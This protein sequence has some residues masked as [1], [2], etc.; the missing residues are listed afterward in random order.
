LICDQGAP[1][2]RWRALVYSMTW[3]V[4]T[5][6]CL[7]LAC[8]AAAGRAEAHAS[9]IEAAPPDG[10]VVATAPASVRLRFNEPV[11]LL[12]LR[13]IDAKGVTHTDLRYAGRDETITIMLPGDLPNG[14]QVLSYRVTSSDG[15][16]IGGSLIFSIGAPTASL[17][18]QGAGANSLLAPAIWLARLALYVGLFAGAGGAFFTTW[19]G[20]KATTPGSLSLIRVATGIGIGAAVV[21]VG[22]QGL[23]ALGLPLSALLSLHPWHEGL[24]TSFGLTAGTA[25]LALLCAWMAMRGSV[26]PVALI[27]L[28]GAGLALALS[29]HASAASPQWLTRFS[30]FLHGLAAAFWIGALVPL[31]LIVRDRRGASLPIVERF[32]AIAVPMVGVMVLAGLILSVVQVETPA[33]LLTTAYG[34]VFLV[35]MAVVVCLLAVAVLN[36]QRLSPMLG[37]GSTAS[38]HLARSIMGEIGLAVMILGLVATWRFTPPPRALIAPAAEPVNVHIHTA[39]A[40][41]DMSLRPGRVGPV[42]ITM[43]LATGDLEPLDPKEVTVTLANPSAGIEPM[44][45]RAVKAADGTW[46]VEGLVVP[47]PGRW[48][49][50]VDV[51]ITD[52]EKATLESTVEIR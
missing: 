20:R 40:M 50:R 42:T 24:R 9:L 52:F 32:S 30:V 26:K 17:P 33:A 13:L 36:R 34:Q 1:D 39:P 10:T 44:E 6:F 8:C 28:G 38:Q 46:Q 48:R 12:V 47:V 19:V 2:Q 27:G 35:K 29:G 16:P 23:D 51:L 4:R 37:S 15:H 3:M 18:E 31:A 7:A 5:L 41:V 21:S 43:S 49:A 22:L 14:T 25:I 11:S 45:R